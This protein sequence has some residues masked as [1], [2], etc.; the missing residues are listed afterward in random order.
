MV[1]D[2]DGGAVFGNNSNIGAVPDHVDSRGCV[3]G[4]FF[5]FH[6]ERRAKFVTKNAV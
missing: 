6:I 2:F 4:E 3:A 1:G 5:A